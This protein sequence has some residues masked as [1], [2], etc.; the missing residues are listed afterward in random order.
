M[1]ICS[2]LLSART[3]RVLYLPV[4]YLCVL[5]GE[6]L[7]FKPLIQT[8]GRVGE[9]STRVSESKSFKT[10]TVSPVRPAPEGQRR[11][12]GARRPAQSLTHPS[13]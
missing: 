12:R 5:R 2:P 11:S 8:Q 10:F 1:D 13:L 6:D 7:D 9:D 4:C 3:R